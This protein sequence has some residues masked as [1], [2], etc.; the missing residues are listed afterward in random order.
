MWLFKAAMNSRDGSCVSSRPHLQKKRV[1][2]RR[3]AGGGDARRV[4]G[5]G[6]TETEPR[7]SAKHVLSLV[8][9]LAFET[10]GGTSL[11]ARGPRDVLPSSA[12]RDAYRC[13]AC[14]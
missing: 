13:Y 12:L 6:G 3:S 11:I 1:L 5:Q 10:L 4:N 9:S 7:G 8:V 2:K 14:P